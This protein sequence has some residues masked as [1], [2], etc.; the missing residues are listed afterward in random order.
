[1]FVGQGLKLSAR[2]IVLT[3]FAPILYAPLLYAPLLYAQ[4][5]DIDD[6]AGILSLDPQTLAVDK[7][8]Q[9]EFT[10]QN[11]GSNGDDDWSSW[12]EIF[13]SSAG[14]NNAELWFAVETVDAQDDYQCFAQFKAPYK[15]STHHSDSDE[16]QTIRWRWHGEV[17]YDYYQSTFTDSG[18]DYEEISWAG[19]FG[20]SREM[21]LGSDTQWAWYAGL[22]YQPI[23]RD[24]QLINPV[25]G[26]F[27]SADTK[28]TLL[29]PT[30]SVDGLNINGQHLLR[31]RIRYRQNIHEADESQDKFAVDRLGRFDTRFRFRQ[32]ELSGEL[33]WQ[34]NPDPYFLR[35]SF[36][37]LNFQVNV[38]YGFGQRLLPQVQWVIGG[39]DTVRGYEGG[40][41]SADSTAYLRA[42]YRHHW[43]GNRDSALFPI[44]QQQRVYL[45]FDTAYAMQEAG[46]LSIPL[47]GGEYRVVEQTEQQDTLRS[48]GF[49]I[50]LQLRYGIDLKL[51]SGW[52]IREIEGIADRGDQQWH[53]S[54]RWRF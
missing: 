23:E 14:D 10:A 27:V 15:A 54:G 24:G 39:M 53:A 17:F 49:G 35:R 1:M 50:D 52:V 29:M 45:F 2:F 48:S 18:S 19:E 28:Q 32:L 34:L 31:W 47:A 41:L 4:A 9:F 22:R 25:T 20:I 26:Q 38:M 3:M 13:N 6:Y 16:L 43:R 42:E 37:S 8:W 33:D 7:G 12:L 30:L 46:R 44:W 21:V 51:E 5:T 40:V 11:K 36:H